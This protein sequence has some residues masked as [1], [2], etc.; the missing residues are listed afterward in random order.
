MTLQ[1]EHRRVTTFV[2][3]IYSASVKTRQALNDGRKASYVGD[4]ME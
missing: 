3:Q 4:T 2:Q 1:K